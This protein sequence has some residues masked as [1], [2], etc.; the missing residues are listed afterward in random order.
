MI[1]QKTLEIIRE[2]PHVFQLVALSAHQQK[3]PLLHIANE[4]SV[5]HSFLTSQGTLG[6]CQFLQSASYDRVVVAGL[7]TD[8]V[9]CAQEVLRRGKSLAIATKEILV[10]H[11]EELVAISRECG[12]EILPIDSEISAI[13]QCLQGREHS[14]IARV[15]LTASGGPFWDSKKFPRSSFANITPEMA[16]AHPK[17]NMGLPR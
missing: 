16:I 2:Y 10:S 11:G 13:W 1:G 5:E 17:W 4:F 12:G 3:I 6:L 9:P 8:L 7:G 14:S 15:F